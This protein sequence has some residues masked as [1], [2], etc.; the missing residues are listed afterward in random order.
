MAVLIDHTKWDPELKRKLLDMLY[1]KAELR[2]NDSFRRNEFEKVDASLQMRYS[3]NVDM[4]P[5]RSD[6]DESRISRRQDPGQVK[7]VYSSLY[8]P[9]LYGIFQ[10]V[11]VGLKDFIFPVDTDWF[12]FDMSNAPFFDRM[13]MKGFVKWNNRAWRNLI[14][15]ENET[16]N[17]LLEYHTALMQNNAYG[18]T[19]LSHYYCPETAVVDF[20]TLNIQ[21]FALDPPYGNWK[22][23]NKI[24]RSLVSYYELKKNP[25]Y[26]QAFVNALNPIAYD[27]DLDNEDPRSMGPTEVANRI[28][29]GEIP[30]GNIVVHEFSMKNFFFDDGSGNPLIEGENVHFTCVFDAQF[31]DEV[32]VNELNGDTGHILLCAKVLEFDNE[33]GIVYGK[34]GTTMPNVAYHKGVIV[35]LLDHQV[36]VNQ[37]FSGM[38]RKSAL[39]ANPPLTKAPNS[40]STRRTEVLPLAGNRI[41]SD[42]SLVPVFPQGLNIEIDKNVIQFYIE[43]ME[44]FAGV[45]AFNQG[46]RFSTRRTATEVTESSRGADARL[47]DAAVE[48]DKTVLK[49]SLINRVHLNQYY[50]RRNTEDHL[51]ELV[52]DIK[53]FQLRENVEKGSFDEILNEELPKIAIYRRMKTQ[54]RIDEL[55]KE[56]Y[57]QNKRLLLKNQE[58]QN[59][60]VI[61]TNLIQN[62]KVELAAALTE[63]PTADFQPP[64]IQDPATGLT[65]LAVPPEQLEPMVQQH[66]MMKRAAQDE[67][68]VRVQKLQTQIDLM[69]AS[70]KDDL[71]EVAEPSDALYYKVLTYPVSEG[72]VIITGSSAS[73]NRQLERDNMDVFLGILGNVPQL[74]R[75]FSEEKLAEMLT[76]AINVNFTDIA[77][78]QDEL[79]QEEFIAKQ[80]EELMGMLGQQ[81]G[82]QG[83]PQQGQ[84]Q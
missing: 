20:V 13:M 74:A 43:Q 17:F 47:S 19:V 44:K 7:D 62:M 4:L 67:M 34:Y 84:A 63:D 30:A 38:S 15:A 49:P 31:R 79:N 68:A 14:R 39:N 11:N 37:L 77:K 75:F 29:D 73:Q 16:Y 2:F 76:R 26:D 70:I 66:I 33:D 82:Q 5:G 35:P 60:I 59:D 64:V 41:Y 58:L 54:S 50:L 42:I 3:D 53:A 27:S 6:E 9:V 40:T 57:K 12:G 22:K 28:A 36:Y 81:G 25:D 8:L 24:I 72:D 51:E 65:T 32:D 18:G 71:G 52:P 23:S 61:K 56:F 80:Q 10:A 55:Y 69:R 21:D 1:D 48:F 78:S 46:G 83:A 45:T